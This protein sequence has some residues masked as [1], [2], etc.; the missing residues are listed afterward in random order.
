V[1]PLAPAEFDLRKLPDAFYD[2]PYP[3]YDRLRREAPVLRCPDGSYF[4]TRYADVLA[5]YKDHRRFSSDKRSQFGPVMGVG[6]PLF[7]HHTTSLVFND[8]PLHTRVRRAIGNAL[9]ARMVAAMREGLVSI[10]E[11]LLDTMAARRDVDLIAD[12][13]AAIP[14]E[15]IGNLLRVPADER[16][17]LR[18]WSLGI[19]GG[20][21][22]GLSVD[23]RAHGNTC[24]EEFLAYL[25]DF[26]PRRRHSL[27][28][29]DDDILA[30]L[31]RWRDDEH[32]FTP[33]ELYHQCIFLL[34]AGHE[35]TTNL[36]GNGVDLL[37][38]H[39]G[40][41]DRLRADPGLIDSTVEEV[42][43]FESSNQLGNRTV[44]EAAEIGGVRVD[45][46]AILTLCIGAANRDP[47]QFERAD[48]FDITREPNPHLAFGGGIHTCAGLNVAR[49]EGR[50][51]IGRLFERFGNV[52]RTAPARRARRARFR[53]FETLPVRVE[54]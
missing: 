25:E 49:L 22:V 28:G 31:L 3:T 47:L 32:A 38:E 18:R 51:A 12:F 21:E 20:L 6:S 11:G 35:T 5:V 19:L 8:P 14:V 1:N 24:V 2:D 23:Q 33:R 41:Q 15:I 9:S 4:L 13:A 36:I 37:L 42:L 39:T 26:V 45:P 27:S 29:D 52:T 54:S 10:V 48:T 43:R 16:G 40:E 50:V 34:N 30:R 44:L 17:P 7:E 53:G 46:G